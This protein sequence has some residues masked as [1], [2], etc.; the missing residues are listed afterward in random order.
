MILHHRD[1]EA[2]RTYAKTG[3]DQNLVKPHQ[4]PNSRQAPDSAAEIN[5]E[6]W[7]VYPLGFAILKLEIK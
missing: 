3:F 4:P 7:R 5:F 1:T 2:H 6:N